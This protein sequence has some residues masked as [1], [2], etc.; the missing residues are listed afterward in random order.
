LPGD[1]LDILT[2]AAEGAAQIA[3]GH[4]RSDPPKWEKPAGAGPV[5]EADLEVD[6]FLRETLTAARPGYGWLSEESEDDPSRLEA[7]RTFIVDPI[8][9]TR[10]FL[11][12][13]R[14]WAH[15]LAVVEGGTPVAAVVYLPVH[16]EIYTATTT[17]AWLNGAPIVASRRERLDGS[18]VLAPRPSLE[19]RFWKGRAPDVRR[20]FRASLAYRLCAVAEG[21]FDA[22]LTFREAWEW[23]I[24]AGALIARAAGAP[25]SDRRGGPLVFDKPRPLLDGVVVGAPGV[26]AE[27]LSRLADP[28]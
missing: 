5:S 12:G 28:Q 19:A 18:D 25:I 4:W 7:R 3:L 13:E 24:A 16:E 1:D 17:G 22:M 8:D 11:A 2:R 20:H 15:S 23:D 9:G 6:A 10:S 27:I 14:T 21:R 26:H